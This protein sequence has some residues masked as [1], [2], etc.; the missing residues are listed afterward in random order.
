MY[1][2]W[3][4]KHRAAG[5]FLLPTFLSCSYPRPGLTVDAI[6]IKRPEAKNASQLA[7]LLLI[8]RKNDPFKVRHHLFLISSSL[9]LFCVRKPW[10][11]SAIGFANM[12]L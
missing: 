10:I 4:C 5:N 7:E 12:P 9:P 1:K 2:W 6:I 3:T 8:N 11:V